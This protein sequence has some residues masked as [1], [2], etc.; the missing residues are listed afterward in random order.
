MAF[1]S[2]R[3][4]RDDSD[5]QATLDAEVDTVL[6][7]LMNYPPGAE[8]SFGGPVRCP[9]CANFGL[10][11]E[12][13]RVHGRA[14]N[15]CPSCKH[16]W[17]VTMRALRAA[18]PLVAR[19]TGQVEP[20]LADVPLPSLPRSDGHREVAAD[21]RLPTGVLFSRGSGGNVER[22]IVPAFTRPAIAPAADGHG[23][24]VPKPADPM[25][26][27]LVEDDPDDI[28][29]VRA[30]L[31][32][33]SAGIDLRTART[34]AAGEAASREDTPDLVLLDLGLPDSHGMATVTR[35]H[36]NAMETPVLVVSGGYGSDVADRGREFGIS[37]FLDKAELA[38]LLAAGD[39]GTNE[40]L[41]RL[42]AAASSS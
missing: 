28:D 20:R 31:E 35:W 3:R 5:D 18:R 23:L 27:L 7:V 1:L 40:F 24:F 8:L 6:R 36:Y 42:T 13:D 39:A 26:I 34:R 38:D 17:V 41:D 16:A 19:A 11:E 15:R 10:V 25:R 9:L 2:F 12:V 37:G 4:K 29:V 21:E 33:V 30:I 14:F 22:Q 32:P